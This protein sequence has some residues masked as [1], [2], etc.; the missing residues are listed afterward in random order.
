MIRKSLS[1]L[2]ALLFALVL[3]SSSAA[4]EDRTL[5]ILFTH[6]MHSYLE[7][8]V[9]SEDG[10]RREHGNAAR[11]ATLIGENRTENTLVLDAGDFSMGTLFGAGYSTDAYELRML[12]ALGYDATT[13][14]NHEM[15]FGGYGFASMLNAAAA[16]GD[17][18]PAFV[19]SNMVLTGELTDEQRAVRDAM[20]NVGAVP[21][22]ILNDGSLRVAV[23]GLLGHDGVEC[24]P[25]SGMAFTDYI[26]SAKET[27]AA[28]GDSA[29]VIVC[30]SHSGTDGNGTG[31]EDIELAKSVPE[32]DLIISAHSHTL[33]TEPVLSGDT[34]IVSAGEYANFLGSVTLRVDAQGKASV[35]SYELL[36]VDETVPEDPE[37]RALLER[38]KDEIRDGYLGGEDFDAVVARTPFDF[39][40][41]DTLYAEHGENTLGNL[42]AD[43]YLY[44]AREAGI[45][46]IDVALAPLGTIR[47]TFGTGDITLA[48]VFE[49]CSLGVGSDGS[50]G[51]PLV[52]AYVTGRELKLLIELDASAGPLV[53]SIK[54][55]YAGLSYTFNTRRML[56]DRV[57]D[58]ALVRA[59]GSRE[60]IEDGRRYKLVCNM[61]AVNMLG[62]LNGLS[63]GLLSITP[64]DE[65]GVP[66]T[67]FYAFALRDADG[68]EIKEWTALRDYFGSFPADDSGVPVIGEQYR[69]VEGRKVK[70]S[71]G[72]LAVLRSPGLATWLVILVPPVL[73]AAIAVPIAVCVR[74]RRKKRAGRA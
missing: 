29:D 67:D 53:N 56:L 58:A 14:G 10:V 16:S 52:A 13:L 38:F 40:A 34:V 19:Q 50:A 59:D 61:Y 37:I 32:L 15:D 45:D 7:T 30:L 71:E 33:Y 24:A 64:T 31:G 23:F 20:E 17:P 51:H 48:N 2:L 3:L 69:D 46:D 70:V 6:D 42:I 18:L 21:Y 8:A 62:M 26:Q 41:L 73:L 9:S 55:S 66:V 65:N 28:I 68:N 27:V 25:T 35:L 74:R 72:G 63:R 47:G 60:E 11:L 1:V 4:A 57:T 5:H 54:M 43:S 39:P 44:A 36:P 22:T 12:G 49:V